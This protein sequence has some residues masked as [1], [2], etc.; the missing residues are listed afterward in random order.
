MPLEIGHRTVKKYIF[1][2]SASASVAGASGAEVSAGASDAASGEALTP[3]RTR[4]LGRRF[5]LGPGR[6]EAG[7]RPGLPRLLV[8]K[9]SMNKVSFACG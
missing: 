9:S 1:L 3:P 6:R 7:R 5:S 8:T 4:G 2:T